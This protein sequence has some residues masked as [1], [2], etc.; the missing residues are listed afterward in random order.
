MTTEPA[1]QRPEPSELIF[2]DFPDPRPGARRPRLECRPSVD[3]ILQR[4]DPTLRP[5]NSIAY[6]DV[7]DCFASLE[8]EE[9]ALRDKER[10]LIKLRAETLERVRL[11]RETE[12]LLDARER[13]LDQREASIAERSADSATGAGLA[14]LEK[15]LRESRQSLTRA[16]QTIAEKDELIGSLRADLEA[17]KAQIASGPAADGDADTDADP[18][19]PITHKTLTEQVAFLR[20]REAFIEQSENVLFDKAQHLQE[21]ETRLQQQSHDQGGAN[22]ERD[23]AGNAPASRTVPIDFPRSAASG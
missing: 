20:E 3:A 11:V 18:Y 5:A 7:G 1:S 2:A 15:S 14:A 19:R 17:L 8:E 12:I 21:W 6:I 9:T 16:N 10:E 4:T 13:I 22:A 23:G